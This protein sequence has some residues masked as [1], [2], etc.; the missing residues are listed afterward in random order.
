MQEA[1]QDAMQDGWL[2]LAEAAAV[3]GVSPDTVRR[4]IRRGELVAMQ[5]DRHVRVRL[6]PLH[7]S[8]HGSD[9]VHSNLPGSAVQ[10]HGAAMHEQSEGLV[11]AVRLIGRLQEENRVM[12]GRIG[13]LEA[14]LDH[15]RALPA[16][17]VPHDAQ[18]GHPSRSAV[19]TSSTPSESAHARPGFWTRLRAALHG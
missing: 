3:L 9:G 10:E 15:A 18:E 6:N 12:A 8:V 2:T 19:E 11:E 13:W 4:R 17:Q 7:G 1:V 14:Q 5:Q 16:P